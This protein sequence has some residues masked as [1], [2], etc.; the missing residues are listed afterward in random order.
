MGRSRNFAA[1]A[2]P[3]PFHE[4]NMISGKQRLQNLRTKVNIIAR[5]NLRDFLAGRLGVMP[6]SG[7]QLDDEVAKEFER[8]ELHEHQLP[9]SPGR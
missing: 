7:D 3:L 9:P 4:A 6:C 8:L 2:A 1:S 5:R